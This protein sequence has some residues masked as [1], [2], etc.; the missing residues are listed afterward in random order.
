MSNLFGKTEAYFGK[1]YKTH[2]CGY[3]TDSWISMKTDKPRSPNL[4]GELGPNMATSF[5][6]GCLGHR[7]GRH[8]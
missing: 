4:R 7:I 3:V 2:K 1:I 5:V 8:V 6:I